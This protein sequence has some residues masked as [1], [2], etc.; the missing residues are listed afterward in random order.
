MP[1]RTRVIVCACLA[2]GL[3]GIGYLTWAPEP[4]PEP[5]HDPTTVVLRVRMWNG[6]RERPL[7]PRPEPDIT[8][9]GDG[10]IILTGSE[11]GVPRRDQVWDAQLTRDAYREIYR[12]VHRAGL[13]TSRVIR[14]AK[15]VADAEPDEI[16]FLAGG[17]W[18]MTTVQAG[19]RDRAERIYD[20]WESIHTIHWSRGD[21]VRPAVTYRPARMAIVAWRPGKTSGGSDGQREGRWPLRPLPKDDKPTCTVL[22]GSDVPRAVRLKAQQATTNY[23]QVWR[24]GPRLYTV[25]FR[26]LLPDEKDCAAI[27]R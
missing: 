7:L 6:V 25:W 26:P 19:A 14:A 13:A 4:V 5:P 20:L 27:R 3:L 12:D 8:V 21:L 10:R 15:Q 23:T 24:S 2:A 11:S 18:H 9:Y 17:R 1:K 22:T 16:E